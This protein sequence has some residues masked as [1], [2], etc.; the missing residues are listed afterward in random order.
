MA[1]VIKQTQRHNCHEE[2]KEV[3]VDLY[4]GSIVE[5]SCGK[6]FKKCDDQ[7]DGPYWSEL[8]GYPYG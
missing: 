4:L 6:R 5:C 8:N 7:R 3:D 2:I 1:K